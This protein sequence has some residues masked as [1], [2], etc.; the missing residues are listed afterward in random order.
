LR[1]P[2]LVEPGAQLVDASFVLPDAALA[3]VPTGVRSD[4]PA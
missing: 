1:F 2:E 3:D 4:T